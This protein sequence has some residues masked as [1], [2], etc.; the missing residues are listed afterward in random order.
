MKID[1]KNYPQVFLEQCKYKIKRRRMVDF[2]DAELDLDS[3]DSDNF[4][5]LVLIY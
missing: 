4:E 3:S 1:K 5:K 2:T